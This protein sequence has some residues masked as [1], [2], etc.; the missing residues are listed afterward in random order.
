[1]KF[2]DLL[3]RQQNILSDMEAQMKEYESADLFIENRT[4]KAQVEELSQSN[5]ELSK[6]TKTLRQKN[7]DLTKALYAQVEAEREGLI[8][9][10]KERL[11]VHFGTV[12]GREMDNLT[13]LEK[14]IQARTDQL[15]DALRRYHVEMGHP[16]YQKI[17]DLQQESWHIV[18]DAKAK[19]AEQKTA[20]AQAD[21]DAFNNLKTEPLA[22]W[23]VTELAKKFNL[24]RFVGLNLLSTI[25]IILIVI[26]AIFVG[27]FTVRQLTDA[28]RAA[29]IFALGGGMLVAGEFVNR[30]KASVLSLV[31]TAG[32]IA[33]L[34]V[35]LAFSY[36]AL[37]IF[38]M[39]PALVIC[40]TVTATAFVLSTRYKAQVLLIMAF[41]GG[42]MPFF[43]IV[44]DV[45][46]AYGLM[47]HFLILNLLV[48]LVS[49]RMKWVPSAFIGLGFNI[50]AVWA[51]LWLSVTY[52]S[53]FVLM[54]FILLAF[55]NY[56]AVPIIGTY[57]T[58]GQFTMEDTVLMAINTFVSCA[59]MYVAFN[60]FGW[61]DYMGILAAIYAVV[62]FGLA[63]ILWKKF[64]NANVMRDLAALTGFVFFMLIV[65]LQF[66]VMWLSLGWLVQGVA[67][68]IYGI[69]KLNRRVRYAGLIIFA[70]CFVAF[71]FHDL[72]SYVTHAGNFDSFQFGLRYLAV[73]LG[74]VLI[75]GAYFFK[76][77][78][79]DDLHR[80]YKTMVLTNMW[81]YL[82][83]LASH[84]S[85]NLGFAY[86]LSATYLM[87]AVQMILS[88]GL[89]YGFSRAKL[90]YDGGT[91]G[92]AV[93][94]Y[95]VGIVGMVIL[96]QT[97]T[98]AP[99]VAGTPGVTL[100]ATLVIVALSGLSVLA[101]RDL[102]RHLI[103][104]EVI[105]PIF[106]QVALTVYGLAI[107]TQNV[108]IHYGVSFTNI[109]LSVFYILAALGSIS[110]GFVKGHMLMRRLGL[111]LA[112]LAVGKVFL[113]DLVGL[114]IEQRIISF[115]VM[116]VMLTGIG[117]I[118]QQFS[119]RM[120]AKLE[121]AEKAEEPEPE[122]ES[123]PEV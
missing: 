81:I 115:F 66:D 105:E 94:M 111:A 98:L 85:D 100:S 17:H 114:G 50:I 3:Q 90:L 123:E 7:A 38:G 97:T 70:L 29:G 12:V 110:Y 48:L 64:D 57:V 72:S 20:L 93:L 24:E 16:L 27:Q 91:T 47:V 46:M 34:Y 26:A 103:F 6:S 79:L 73:T 18:Q 104:R 113:L 35:A 87:I 41:V 15:L 31:V 106:L 88:W 120:E 107:I 74:S 2:Q 37:D 80:V 52:I 1:M 14:D 75:L 60:M 42:H 112:L 101:L 63:I 86:P 13:A 36:F 40:V 43:A 39:I 61:G 62:Y 9:K 11:H 10:S 51:V 77:T 58:K 32:G 19:L 82:I 21:L 28:M 55:L 23:Q 68:A 118:Y 102:L 95:A 54:G 53:P 122:S 49:F 4:L 5:T 33:I 44:M 59:T 108:L 78:P 30:R 89:A 65:P 67:M 116:G 8:A 119:K 96:N 92:L 83:Y 69:I 45:E 71:L 117:F 56:T 76:K 84:L 99:F 109:W 25:G 22:P 121:L